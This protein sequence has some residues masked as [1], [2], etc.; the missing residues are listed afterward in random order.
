MMSHTR[1]AII[2]CGVLLISALIVSI[3]RSMIQP[4]SFLFGSTKILRFE[5]RGDHPP[6]MTMRVSRAAIYSR[7][8]GVDFIVHSILFPNRVGAIGIYVGS[9]P[10]SFLD[11]PEM[12]RPGSVGNREVEWAMG[13]HDSDFVAETVIPLFLNPGPDYRG[14]IQIDTDYV[15]LW[16]SSPT[17]ENLSQLIALCE[18]LSLARPRTSA[19]AN[20]SGMENPAR[21]C[22]NCPP[23][24]PLLGA[25]S[26]HR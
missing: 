17:E 20:T 3:V 1:I 12:K 15:H 18:G 6:I 9:G 22:A 8:D 14:T 4:D 7:S 11:D 21:F 25:G 23:L 24:R 26:I 10:N 13:R 16:A 2:C 19:G 5:G